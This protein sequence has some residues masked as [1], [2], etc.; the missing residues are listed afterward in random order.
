MHKYEICENI[1]NDAKV[2]KINIYTFVTCIPLIKNMT[3]TCHATLEQTA[4]SSQTQV[5]QWDH[6][7]GGWIGDPVK[8]E[9]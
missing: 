3:V 7:E 8:L 1:V 9:T 4:K 2:Y 5:T 6:L